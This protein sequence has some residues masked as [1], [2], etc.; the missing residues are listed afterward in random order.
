[1]TIATPTSLDRGNGTAGGS[2]TTNSVTATTGGVL[3][4]FTA[5]GGTTERSITGIAGLGGTWTHVVHDKYLDGITWR[6]ECWVGVGCTGTGTIVV[7]FSGS[8]S[9][10][11]GWMLIQYASGVDTTTPVVQSASAIVAAGATQVD[12][13]LAAFADATNNGAGGFCSHRVV[14]NLV[15]DASGGWTELDQRQAGSPANTFAYQYKAGQD[16]TVSYSWAST[17]NGAVGLAFEVAAAASGVTGT[18]AWTEAADTC[19]AS[20]TFTTTGTASWTEDADTCAASGWILVTG[21]AAWTE[22]ADTCAASG[23]SAEFVG[24]SA[25]T[26]AADTC[27]ASGTSTPPAVTGTAAWTEAADT[28]TATGTF[29]AAGITGSAAWTEAVDTAA[30]TGTFTTTGTAAWTEAADTVAASGTFTTTGTSAWTEAADTV[31]ATGTFTTTGT[32]SWTEAADT[33]AASGTFTP[34]PITG[35]A[36]WT[37]AADTCAASGTAALGTITG[38]GTLTSVAVLSGLRQSTAVL[39]GLRESQA[40]LNGQRT[41]K[42]VQ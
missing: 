40:A 26:E 14:E 29:T 8:W 11:R 36:A 25:W 7:T 27:A 1:M 33:C 42:K 5:C 9:S 19:S 12:V 6:A 38:V 4:L 37:E 35:T 21:T 24:T 15:P 31:A 30:G 23:V 17:T 3:F 39:S 2:I 13:T 28:S 18:A 32:A 16:T 41:S 20:G 10:G 34:A 22:A